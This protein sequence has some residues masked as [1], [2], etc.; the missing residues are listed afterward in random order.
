MLI[1]ILV[2]NLGAPVHTNRDSEYRFCCPHCGETKY[3]LYVS[4]S[5][6]QYN[7]Y[8]CGEF[9]GSIIG[10]LAYLRGVDYK[11]AFELYREYATS[12]NL[13]NDLK[14]ELLEKLRIFDI[15]KYMMKSPIPLP[16]TF[17]LLDESDSRESRRIRK[18]LHSRLVT[19]SQITRHKFGYCYDGEY[20][21]RAILPIYEQNELQ[22][23]VARATR[24]KAYKKEMSPTN[25]DYQISKSEA[26]FNLDYAA[27]NYGS[28][29]L[30]EGI[31][32]ACAFNNLGCSLLGKMISNAQLEKIL[33]YKNKL[34]N[35]V[36]MAL[37]EDAINY[38]I[39]AA[40]ELSKYI[41]VYMINVKDDPNSMGK[42]KCLEAL[43]NAE[44]YDFNYKLKMKLRGF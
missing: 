34:V 5:K 22:F 32:D 35:G 8:N 1:D 41:N 26:I 24:D 23:W 36:Y 12:Y 37:D 11:K 28:A 30:C 39:K 21:S 38:N 17:T 19:D 10:L 16:E 7:C 18:V 13:S 14:D 29:V 3:R 20:E 33:K 25:E 27:E 6:G 43:Q 44:S 42:T 4:T 2:E 40:D 15:D 31:Y 9:H